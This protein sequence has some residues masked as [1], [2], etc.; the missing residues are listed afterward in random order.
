MKKPDRLT[1]T[2]PAAAAK[3]E[4]VPLPAPAVPPD[5]DGDAE[6]AAECELPTLVGYAIVF[7]ATSADDRKARVTKDTRIN[8]IDTGPVFAFYSHDSKDVLGSTGNGTLRL[9]ADAYGLRVEIDPPDTS[10]ARD[11]CELVEDGYVRGMSFGMFPVKS[12]TVREG[13]ETVT[14]YDEIIV[15]EVT[16]TCIPAFPETSIGIQGDGATPI[17]SAHKARAEELKFLSLG[18]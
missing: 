11:V 3:F 12:H 16:I 10:Y 1:F 8:F 5:A 7:G 15:D 14:V 13:G 18:L 17:L 4:L 9:N 2:T 6:D